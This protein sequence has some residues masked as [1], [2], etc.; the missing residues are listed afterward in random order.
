MMLHRVLH[1]TLPCMLHC[2]F[3]II[4]PSYPLTIVGALLVCAG[5]CTNVPEALL[6]S[7]SAAQLGGAL[8]NNNR[9]KWKKKTHFLHCHTM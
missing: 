2:M 6:P 4:Y 8:T 9:L 3:A 5:V 7:D 1:C